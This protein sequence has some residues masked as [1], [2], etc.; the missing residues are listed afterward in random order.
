MDLPAKQQ[1]GNGKTPGSASAMMKAL[2]YQGVGK[3]AFIEHAK[4]VIIDP[5][6]AIVRIVKTTICGTDLHILKGDLASCKPGR[7][8]GH[9][10]VG[11]IDQVGPAVTAFKAGDRVLISCVSACGKCEYCREQMFSHCVHWRLD[12]RQ[13]HRRHPGA[14]RA[15]TVRRHQPL[16]DP[17]RRGRGGAGDA[18]RHP[19][20]RFRMRRA[21]RQGAAGKHGR[22]RR[23]GTRSA[24]PPCSRRSSTRPARSS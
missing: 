23:I 10:G 22:H 17:G 7:I 15:H 6:D 2:V 5:T 11:V 12:S 8:L 13:H 1:P 3:K 9:E 4:P 18:E 14:V 19:A 16:S 21:Q 24:W 20:H